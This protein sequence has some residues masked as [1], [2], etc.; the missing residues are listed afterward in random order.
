MKAAVGQMMQD[1]SGRHEFT[2]NRMDPS[3]L[4][5]IWSGEL[6]DP[7]AEAAITGALALALLALNRAQ[8]PDA[9]QAQAQKIWDARQKSRLLAA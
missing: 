8:E 6:A 3:R 2:G 1:A 9:A 7:Y 4:Q 5:K